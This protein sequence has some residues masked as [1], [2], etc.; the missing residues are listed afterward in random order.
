MKMAATQLDISEVSDRVYVSTVFVAQ[1][2]ARLKEMGIT[3]LVCCTYFFDPNPAF[4]SRTLHIKMK[5]QN[6]QRVLAA[7]PVAVKFICDALESD[8][9]HKVLVHCARGASRSGTVA[10][11]YVMATRQ[12]SF[13]EAWKEV[14]MRRPK[15]QPVEGFRQQL[16]IFHR[17][18]YTSDTSRT[19]ADDPLLRE[20]EEFRDD[21]EVLF[22]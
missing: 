4:E 18:G 8:P 15:V 3:H 20:L 14:R 16:K 7:L 2:T 10:V 5:D 13:E 21:A 12:C 9:T 17:L 22:K 6:H 19:S 1:K 11:A